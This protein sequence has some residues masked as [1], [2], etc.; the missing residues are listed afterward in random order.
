MRRVLL[1]LT[2][3][4]AL[5]LPACSKIWAQAFAGRMADNLLSLESY[6]GELHQRGLLP[7][8]PQTELVQDVLYARP[9][10]VRAEVTAPADLKG[11][12][13]LYDG[14]QMVM[15]WPQELFGIRVRG[16]KNPARDEVVAHIDREMQNAMDNYAFALKANQK[17][18]GHAVSRWQML[19]LTQAPY[20]LPHTAW[21]QDDYSL[22]LKMEFLDKGRPWYGYE[23]SKIDFNVPVPTDA[24][25]FDFPENAVVF[26]W[27]MQAP[28]LSLE[29]AQRKMNFSILQ[30]QQLPT[31]FVLRKLVPSSHCLPMLAL[32][33]DHGASVLT[34][35]ESR[36]VLPLPRFGKP[37]T[38]GEST[39]WLYFAG[40]YS[41]LSWVQGKTALTLTSNLSFPQVIAIA[42]SV[43]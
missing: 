20:R 11:T 41:I 33:Y 37:V 38:I 24:F 14:E 43:R 42:R 4:F 32:Q 16:L 34:L 22:P 18:A 27:D 1:L 2:V 29:A 6:H 26:E 7:D 17:V 40:N 5:T 31:G 15:W 30:P 28:G 36:A 35:T 21:M 39:G 12:L 3:F 23:F 9:W 8:A 10:R 25:A 19:P 13:F